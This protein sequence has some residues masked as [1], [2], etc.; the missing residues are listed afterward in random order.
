[1]SSAWLG[2]HIRE[3][4]NRERRVRVNM[5]LDKYGMK[6]T[7]AFKW[8]IFSYL[9]FYTVFSAALEARPS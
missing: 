7:V 9:P 3:E 1:M 4:Q 2:A 5:L 6:R 8:S